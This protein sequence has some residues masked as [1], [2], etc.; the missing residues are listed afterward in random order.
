MHSTMIIAG[1]TPC[2]L[3]GWSATSTARTTSRAERHSSKITGYGHV[4]HGLTP[5]AGAGLARQLIA[6]CQDAQAPA[7]SLLEHGAAHTGRSQAAA[8]EGF[9][10]SGAVVTS[11]DLV[12]A[13]GECRRALSP[14]GMQFG[15]AQGLLYSEL[16]KALDLAEAES[17][18]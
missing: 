16:R 18:E 17:F 14:E 8:L 10:F 12:R 11:G 15:H 6:A 9:R 2:R 5:N 3:W 7:R 4:A 1:L 13:I